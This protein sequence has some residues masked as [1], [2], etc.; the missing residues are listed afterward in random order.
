MIAAYF[1]TR[2]Y[3]QGHADV[4][5]KFTAAMNKSLSYAAEHPD[6]ARAVLLT[7]TK[8]DKAVAEKLNLPL[9]SP[10]INRDSISLLADLMVQDKLVP[11]KPDIDA[12][13]R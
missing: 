4:V 10:Q 5:Q 1:T 8:I 6:E 7:Y 9:W 2:D 3:A 11:S 12:L 13:L